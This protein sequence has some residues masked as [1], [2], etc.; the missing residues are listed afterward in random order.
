MNNKQS[1]VEFC[2]EKGYEAYRSMYENHRRRLVEEKSN[3]NFFSSAMPGYSCLFLKKGDNEIV[4]G[5]E[6][7]INGK[8][9]FPTLIWPKPFGPNVTYTDRAFETMTYEEILHV[10]ETYLENKKISTILENTVDAIV[11][12]LDDKKSKEIYNVYHSKIEKALS[13]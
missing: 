9:H 10:I 12:T 13:L 7:V 4:W 1:F 8:T 3:L 2:I 11:D 6:E 5:L